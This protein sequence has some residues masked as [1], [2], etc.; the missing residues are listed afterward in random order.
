MAV[1]GI[2]DELRALE[3]RLSTDGLNTDPYTCLV[4]DERGNREADLGATYG[5]YVT[6]RGRKSR[7]RNPS[8]GRSLV[9]HLW[10]SSTDSISNLRVVDGFMLEF[11]GKLSSHSQ[12][13]E[14]DLQTVH[15]FY[16]S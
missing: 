5:L 7:R 13:V 1:L 11:Q 8:V 9:D 12:R 16:S 14:E 6:S 4:V 2:M 10:S 3:M 15:E